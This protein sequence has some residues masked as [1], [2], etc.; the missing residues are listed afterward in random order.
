MVDKSLSRITEPGQPL[1]YCYVETL[2][3]TN[4]MIK[5][6]TKQFAAL[7]SLVSMAKIAIGKPPEELKYAMNCELH[8]HNKS[9]GINSGQRRTDWVYFD[10]VAYE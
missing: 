10:V 5:A 3:S 4:A 8:L 2:D 6:C 7:H 1:S 9:E